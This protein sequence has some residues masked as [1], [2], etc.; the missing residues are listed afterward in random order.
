MLREILRKSFLNFWEVMILAL[1]LAKIF[2]Y[3]AG[4]KFLKP[5]KE[6]ALRVIWKLVRWIHAMRISPNLS[7]HTHTR[8]WTQYLSSTVPYFRHIAHDARIPRLSNKWT[9]VT[10]TET[11]SNGIISAAKPAKHFAKKKQRQ[12]KIQKW[13]LNSKTIK[14]A[15]QS[16]QN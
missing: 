15:N 6:E 2:V 1:K 9:S 8:R 4:H 7:S 11:H 14:A 5:S 12:K 10:E 16:K 13:K 3:H